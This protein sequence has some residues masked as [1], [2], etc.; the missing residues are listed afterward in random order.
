MKALGKNLI[1]KPVEEE[2]KAS[3]ILTPKE[4]KPVCWEV[5]SIGKD[6][7]EINIGDIVYTFSYCLQ[8]INDEEKLY[9]VEME[10]VYAKN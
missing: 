3:L 8:K 6:V 2:K 9:V 10:K 5:I 1:V 4:E 7:E